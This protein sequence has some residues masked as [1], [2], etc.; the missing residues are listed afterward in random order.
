MGEHTD[1][2]ARRPSN[3]RRTDAIFA[4]GEESEK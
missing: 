3:L 4:L 2:G 1:K